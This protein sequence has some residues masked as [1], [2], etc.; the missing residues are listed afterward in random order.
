MNILEK[1]VDDQMFSVNY[2]LK[3]SRIKD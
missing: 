3:Q 1:H 2:L